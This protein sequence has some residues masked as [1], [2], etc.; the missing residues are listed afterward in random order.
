M[1][2]LITKFSPKNQFARSVGVLVGGTAG[3][4]LL[5]VLSAPLLTRLYSPE[6]F[7]MLAVYISILSLFTVVAS[8]RYELAIPLPEDDQTAAN[9]LVLCIIIVLFMTGF[10]GLIVT[11]WG[12]EIAVALDVPELANYFWL[13]PIGV[14]LIG[15][16]QVFNYWALRVKEFTVIAKIK[17]YQA[18]T[19]V[20]LQLM[21]FKVGGVGLLAGQVV[22]QGLGSVTLAKSALSKPEICQVSIEGIRCVA[23]RYKHFPLFSTWAGFF[24]TAGSQIP[25]LLFALIFGSVSAGL[26]A[27]ANRVLALPMA[28]VGQAIS[29]VLLSEAAERHRQNSLVELLVVVHRKLVLIITGPVLLLILWGPDLFKFVFGNQWEQ[30]GLVAAWLSLWIFFSFTTSPLSSVYEILERQQLGMWMQFQLFVFRI[31]GILLGAYFGG[32]M[33][34]VAMFS[35]SNML[36]YLIYLI[37][38]F[39]IAGGGSKSIFK[40]Y[41]LPIL[42]ILS[43]VVLKFGALK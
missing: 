42:L 23:V 37:I 28:F 41:A 13:L 40:N 30:A 16:F 27:L 33:T 17:I 3:A 19:T 15:T 8:L 32:F 34:A 6:D 38:L 39:R 14:L 1:K 10:S 21:T 5:L 43:A 4:Q 22:G 29:S 12:D 24:N 26:Y 2:N 18:I 36:S 31:I 7:G 9:I 35:V 20:S 11:L 25:P